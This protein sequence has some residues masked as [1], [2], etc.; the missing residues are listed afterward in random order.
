MELFLLIIKGL[1]G[2]VLLSVGIVT[3]LWICLGNWD[4][5]SSIATFA[6][7][8]VALLPIFI[9]ASR[10]RELTKNLRFQILTNLTMLR[11]IVARRFTN[12]GLGPMT[13]ETF[14]A[15]EQKPI[16]AL[17]LA[18]SQAVMLSPKEHNILG[19]IVLNLSGM[20]YTPKVDP[21]TAKNM[22]ELIDKAREVMQEYK[23]LRGKDKDL[24]SWVQFD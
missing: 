4:A 17:E 11:P 1:L 16:K 15:E 13:S 10:Q 6:V 5:A 18:F 23:Y 20:S 12:T 19:A 3:T 22:L 21:T 7:V 2:L 14:T 8:L 24:P 9:N